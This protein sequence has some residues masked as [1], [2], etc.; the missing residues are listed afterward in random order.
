MAAGISFRRPL[1]RN[2]A[3]LSFTRN[4]QRLRAA[5]TIVEQLVHGALCRGRAGRE[6]DSD[7]ASTFWF[8]WVAR[9]V[10]TRRRSIVVIS[11]V[12]TV[13]ARELSSQE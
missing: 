7:D 9:A 13:R 6:V 4:R 11:K 10:P 3:L 1:Q 12:D 5:N 2:D 8:E